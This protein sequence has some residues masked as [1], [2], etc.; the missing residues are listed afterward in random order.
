M[1]EEKGRGSR[2]GRKGQERDYTRWDKEKSK[3]VHK[4][5]ITS[6]TYK[7]KTLRGISKAP[8]TGVFV[9]TPGDGEKGIRTDTQHPDWTS[10]AT[11]HPMQS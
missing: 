11:K 3:K 5:T 10:F 9:H 1:G 8:H 7:C 6:E 4:V 2:E